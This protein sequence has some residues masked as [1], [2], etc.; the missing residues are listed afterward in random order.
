MLEKIIVL[1]IMYILVLGTDIGKLRKS[2]FREKM[3]YF[4]VIMITLYFGIDYIIEPEL[5][6]LDTLADLVL[7]PPA[8][9]IMKFLKVNPT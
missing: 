1:S 9:M 8:R 6:D 4:G 2:R 7:T 5:P 3:I